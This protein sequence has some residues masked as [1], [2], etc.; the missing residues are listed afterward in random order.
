MTNIDLEFVG[1]PLTPEGRDA[2]SRVLAVI[3]S[4]P[5]RVVHRLKARLGPFGL[6]RPSFAIR[7]KH[8]R[9]FVRWLLEEPSYLTVEETTE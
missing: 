7:A 8:F 9:G 1:E 3:D 4:D 5:R 6:F 2:L